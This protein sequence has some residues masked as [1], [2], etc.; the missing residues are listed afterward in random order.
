MNLG[1]VDLEYPNGANAL[2]V[3]LKAEEQ[4]KA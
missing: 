4:S 1:L 3:D 2:S